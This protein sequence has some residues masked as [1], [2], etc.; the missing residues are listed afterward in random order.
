MQGI[1]YK[2]EA[3]ITERKRKRKKNRLKMKIQERTKEMFASKRMRQKLT[4]PPHK[5]I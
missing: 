2:C 3:L 5:G 1:L 4:V